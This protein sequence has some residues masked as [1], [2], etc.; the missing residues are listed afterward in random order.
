MPWLKLDQ[1]IDIAFWPIVI[2]N[3]RSEKSQLAD[4]VLLAKILDLRGG[5][6]YFLL[7][8]VTV[9]DVILA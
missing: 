7:K 8:S 4:M 3:H 9:S 1:D 2:S 5:K 6:Q